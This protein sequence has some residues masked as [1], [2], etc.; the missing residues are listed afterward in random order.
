VRN[1]GVIINKTD[2]DFALQ[3]AVSVA[4]FPL[5]HISRNTNTIINIATWHSTSS[6]S[7]PVYNNFSKNLIKCGS[8]KSNKTIQNL[9]QWKLWTKWEDAKVVRVPLQI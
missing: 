6:R 8:M 3:L 7:N 4:K 1:Q 5:N 9:V 2:D